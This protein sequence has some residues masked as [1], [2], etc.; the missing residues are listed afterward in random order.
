MPAM[1]FFAVIRSLLVLMLLAPAPLVA[2]DYADR[3]ALDQLFEQL[4]EAPDETAAAAITGKI[5]D[6]WMTPTDSALAVEMGTVLAA[7]TRG[8]FGTCLR[9]LD[10][11]V[12]EYPDYAEGWNRRATIYYLLDNFEGSLADIDK[13]LAIEPRHFGALS[14]KI[15]IELRQGKRNDALR[16][17][18]AA[19]AIHPYL[20]T[21]ELFPELQPSVTNI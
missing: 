10:R 1:R 4:H 15:M 9:L 20:S 5:W 17:M 19:L 18:L 16:D 14:G 21:R 13:V 2:A 12:V 7:E 6:L 11:M 8:D 3:A